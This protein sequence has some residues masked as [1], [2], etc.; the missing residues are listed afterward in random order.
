MPSVVLRHLVRHPVLGFVADLPTLL[1]AG[2]VVRWAVAGA[3]FVGGLPRAGAPLGLLRGRRLAVAAA[4]AVDHGQ[5]KHGDD[6]EPGHEGRDADQEVAFDGELDD[7]VRG[8]ARR[9]T[10]GGAMLWM[11]MHHEYPILS[12]LSRPNWT[13]R[14]TRPGFPLPHAVPRR[15][16][17]VGE[18]DG[19]P[20]D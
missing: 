9:M 15:P 4:E 11:F 17:P 7:R 10:G 16:A 20:G 6:G 19:W 14:R 18:H 5:D 12:V 2:A 8:Q 3:V 13:K 1:V